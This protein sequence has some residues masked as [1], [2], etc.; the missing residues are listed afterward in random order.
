[1]ELRAR[2]WPMV[3]ALARNV[4]VEKACDWSCVLNAGIDVDGVVSRGTFFESWVRVCEGKRDDGREARVRAR[5][6]DRIGRDI[7]GGF[8]L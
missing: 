3:R 7:F 8:R 4:V 6:K 1:M 5:V 2:S